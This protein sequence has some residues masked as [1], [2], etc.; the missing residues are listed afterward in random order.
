MFG[1][2]TNMLVTKAD[3]GW[4]GFWSQLYVLRRYPRME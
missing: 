2:L 1:L 3:F 4:L